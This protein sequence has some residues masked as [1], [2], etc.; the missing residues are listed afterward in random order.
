MSGY[1][2]NTG[3]MTSVAGAVRDSAS[4]VHSLASKTR[5]SAITAADFGKAHTAAGEPF[6]RLLDK[7]GDLVDSQG[8]AMEDYAKRLEDSRG[9]YEFSEQVNAQVVGNAGEK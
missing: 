7:L 9:G 3:E 6:D 4:D 1:G 2:T 8:D 5:R